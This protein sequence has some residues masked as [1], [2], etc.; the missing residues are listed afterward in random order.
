M[1]V[2]LFLARN[3]CTE[4]ADLSRCVWSRWRS[5]SLSFVTCN[6]TDFTLAWILNTNAVC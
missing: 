6:H 3:A 5:Q 2:I 4:K 1:T